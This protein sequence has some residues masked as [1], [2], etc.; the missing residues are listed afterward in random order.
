M[1]D[2]LQPLWLVWLVAIFVGICA[3]VFWPGRRR[4][5]RRHA[6]IPLRDDDPAGARSAPHGTPDAAARPERAPESRK[7]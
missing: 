7:V 4:T 5:M 3:W 1:T 2:V 6:E